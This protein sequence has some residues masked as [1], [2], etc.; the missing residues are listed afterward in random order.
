MSPGTAEYA[1][2][3][4]RPDALHVALL[5]SQYPAA[6]ITVDASEAL[7]LPGVH[8]VLAGDEL[9]KG[10]DPLTN[11]L[12]TPR[13]RRYPLA[14]GRCRYVGEWVAA[15]VAETRAL[16]EDASEK[17]RVHYEAL[18]Y[19]IDAEEAYKPESPPVHPDHGSNVLYDRK[20]T[21][22][23]VERHFAASAHRISHRVVWGRSATVPIETFGVCLMGCVAERS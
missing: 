11:G 20:F 15:V 4:V 23:E 18:P 14:V 21:W 12:D 2:D 7:K 8:Y 19:V 16:A 3:V 17:V 5:A 13:V 6:N 22:G 1:A 10:T 9:A